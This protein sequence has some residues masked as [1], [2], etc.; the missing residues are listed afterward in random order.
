MASRDAPTASNYID[1]KPLMMKKFLQSK[2][3]AW[4][5][6]ILVLIFLVCSFKSRIEWWMFIDVFF[7]FMAAFVNLVVCYIRNINSPV[8]RMLNNWSLIFGLLFILAFIGEWIA[9]Y[10]LF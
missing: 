6:F 4:A 7:L 3:T 1:E 2:V 10:I 5:A 8:A 9:A